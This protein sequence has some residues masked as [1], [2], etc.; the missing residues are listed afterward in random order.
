MEVVGSEGKALD[1]H[2]LVAG[3][4]ADLLD[5]AVVGN[6]KLGEECVAL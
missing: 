2:Q 3:L 4:V 5:R 1:E 6:S